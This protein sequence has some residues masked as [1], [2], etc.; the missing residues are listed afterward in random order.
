MEKSKK[1]PFVSPPRNYIRKLPQYQK[2]DPIKIIK[3]Y[4][5]DLIP[6][7]LV[8]DGL[9]LP[10]GSPPIMYYYKKIT[11]GFVW[12]PVGVSE[13]NPDYSAYYTIVN[14]LDYLYNLSCISDHFAPNEV[15]HAIVEVQDRYQLLSLHMEEKKHYKDDQITKVYAKNEISP[16]DMFYPNVDLVFTVGEIPDLYTH[17][18]YCD[19]WGKTKEIPYT[20]P[21]VLIMITLMNKALPFPCKS[22]SPTTILPNNWYNMRVVSS[23]ILRIIVAGLLGVYPHSKVVANFH[24]RRLVYRHLSLN[25]MPLQQLDEWLKNNRDLVIYLFRDF[26]LY[27]IEGAPALHEMLSNNYYWGT[28]V[29]STRDGMDSIRKWL[30]NNVNWRTSFLPD[31]DVR[32]L[33]ITIEMDLVAKDMNIGQMIN[34]QRDQVDKF[35]V[36][37]TILD[38]SHNILEPFKKLNRKDCPRPIMYS[39]L[40]KIFKK[41]ISIEDANYKS[42]STEEEKRDDPPPGCAEL[43]WEIII[44]SLPDEIPDYTF[45]CIFGVG[46]GTI[47]KLKDAEYEYKMETNRSKLDSV[48]SNIY[49]TNRYDYNI[50]KTFFFALKKR[51]S[52]NVYDLPYEV[53]MAQITRFKQEYGLVAGQSLIPTAGQY[54]VCLSCSTVKTIPKTKTQPRKGGDKKKYKKKKKK[55]NPLERKHGLCH[56]GITINTWTNTKYCSRKPS[57][58]NP[59]RRLNNSDLVSKLT[60]I[61]AAKN[62]KKE[63]KKVSKKLRR[64]KITDTCPVTEL[65]P[66]NSIG[67]IISTPTQGHLYNCTNVSLCFFFKFF[68]KTFFQ[69]LSLTPLSKDSYNGGFSDLPTCGCLGLS[70]NITVDK[71][72]VCCVCRNMIQ[73]PLTTEEIERG[74]RK[75]KKATQKSNYSE[76]LIY[77]DEAPRGS[78]KIYRAKFCW[79]HLCRWIYVWNRVL[80]LSEIRRSLME[81]LHSNVVGGERIF[82]KNTYARGRKMM[83]PNLKRMRAMPDDFG[84]QI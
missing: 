25:V 33:D 20:D 42:H 36:S 77:D 40:D 72:W 67:H 38:A 73:R 5:G 84:Y 35:T 50:L 43:I 27:M 28:V 79:R 23:L 21:A 55:K 68:S 49:D 48:I 32:G 41:M 64:Q 30:N 26:V 54:Y 10:D 22:R 15:K 56:S 61:N 3:E 75:E 57:K 70:K 17:V 7:W 69:C 9:T 2:K 66:Y 63:R 53:T 62:E 44:R 11:E 34:F 29:S 18:M 65:I 82:V 74:G 13:F 60:P 19:I 51:M 31:V 12:C 58:N 6:E 8:L 14:T 46:F 4:F 76:Y 83:Y 71:S 47:Q 16:L 1:K 59:K 39:C 37:Q 78:R 80:R 24:L 81:D 45:L 52:I